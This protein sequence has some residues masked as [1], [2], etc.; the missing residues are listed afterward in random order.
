[1]TEFVEQIH[2]SGRPDAGPTLGLQHPTLNDYL[3]V[4]IDA[5]ESAAS[6]RSAFWG[7]GCLMVALGNCVL[8]ALAG[9]LKLAFLLSQVLELRPSGNRRYPCSP[10]AANLQDFLKRLMDPATGTWGLGVAQRPW[11]VR[12]VPTWSSF[13]D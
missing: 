8:I 9:K 3:P 2:Q 10:V 5:W 12:Q 1:M 13:I 7:D 4:N 11:L 6:A